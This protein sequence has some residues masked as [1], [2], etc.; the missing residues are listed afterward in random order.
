MV[1][2]FSIYLTITT[3]DYFAIEYANNLGTTKKSN[4]VD[5]SSID[6]TTNGNND[7]SHKRHL[8]DL[9]EEF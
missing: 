7:D 3:F 8:L 2:R 5:H 1:R 6:G 9:I 4:G